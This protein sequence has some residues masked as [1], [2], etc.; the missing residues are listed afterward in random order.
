MDRLNDYVDP[1]LP[2]KNR[3]AQNDHGDEKR[4]EGDQDVY[5]YRERVNMYFRLQQES[6]RLPKA[7]PERSPTPNVDVRRWVEGVSLPILRFF[8]VYFHFHKSS[9]A[10]CPFYRANAKKGQRL[11]AVPFSKRNTLLKASF[12]SAACGMPSRR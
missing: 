9:W 1:G 5:R 12:S 4:K 2:V 11:S 7:R 10:I 3:P 6:E 8:G